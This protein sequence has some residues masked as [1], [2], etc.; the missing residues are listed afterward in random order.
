M[1]LQWT[2]S[3]NFSPGRGGQ[4]VDKIVCHWMDAT[5][6]SATKHFQQDGSTPPYAGVS[7][8]FGVEDG[9]V[10]Q[11]VRL[12][13]TAWHSGVFPINQQSVG[14]EFSADPYRPASDETYRTGGDL[15]AML[16]RQYGWAGPIRS[17]LHAHKEFKA[18]ACP[19]TLD[20]DRLAREAEESYA[21]FGA[22]QPVGGGEPA[23]LSSTKVTVFP[24]T[25]KYTPNGWPQATVHTATN[26]RSRCDRLN[27]ADIVEVLQAGTVQDVA[28][29]VPG[30]EFKGNR[31]WFRKPNG[32]YF[33]TGNTD[34]DGSGKL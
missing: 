33:W 29:V 12:E 2:T 23:V 27:D 14:I 22:D 31:L 19:G 34:Y 26:V 6:D 15:I 28:S 7:A 21:S 5:L 11:F 32:L 13:D 3:P 20:L 10:R 30:I 25:G 24:D 1:N 17:Y 8:H 18:T 16:Y 9:T 4:R